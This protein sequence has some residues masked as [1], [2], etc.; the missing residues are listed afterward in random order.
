MS[1]TQSRRISIPRAG[2]R[3]RSIG[4]RNSRIHKFMM[5][6]FFFLLLPPFSS[7]PGRNA[8]YDAWILS[9]STFYYPILSDTRERPDAIFVRYLLIDNMRSTLRGM[10]YRQQSDQSWSHTLNPVRPIN[11]G[12]SAVS[13]P[14]EGC[15]LWALRAP[16]R[17]IVPDLI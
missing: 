15:A 10:K 12:R 3:S 9:T 4:M 1:S 16:G 14:A 5:C 2:S 17:C 13:L 11:L 6:T 7:S 8:F